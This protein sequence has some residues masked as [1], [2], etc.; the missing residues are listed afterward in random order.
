MLCA[1]HA[2]RKNI[3][4]QHAAFEH[5]DPA[6]EQTAMSPVELIVLLSADVGGSIVVKNGPDTVLLVQTPSTPDHHMRS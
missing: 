2:K 6:G 1:V 4:E 3:K 5:V